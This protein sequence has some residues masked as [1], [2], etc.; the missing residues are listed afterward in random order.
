V[1][2]HNEKYKY[3]HVRVFVAKTKACIGQQ[4]KAERFGQCVLLNFSAYLGVKNGANAAC[5][6]GQVAMPLCLV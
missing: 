6:L 5:S 4:K 3:M 1:T 2:R